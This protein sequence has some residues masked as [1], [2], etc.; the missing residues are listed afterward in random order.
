[1]NADG[2]MG[3]EAMELGLQQAY[4]EIYMPAD[5][6]PASMVFVIGDIEANTKLEILK[7]RFNV[8]STVDL[9]IKD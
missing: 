9:N 4:K 8:P 7:A 3:R 2:G 1:M 6:N 5:G